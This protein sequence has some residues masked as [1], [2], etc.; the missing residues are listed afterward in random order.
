VKSYK[1]SLK[2]PKY[3]RFNLEPGKRT[4]LHQSH[5]VELG[6][7]YTDYKIQGATVDK[8]IL[9]LQKR[10]CVPHLTIG[11]VHVGL[12]RVKKGDDIRIW[13]MDITP[14]SVQHLTKLRRSI[15][16]KIWKSNYNNGRWDECGL[17]HISE[18]EYRKKIL[19]LNKIDLDTQNVKKLRKLAMHLN[20]Q[21]R[22]IPQTALIDRLKILQSSNKKTQK[23]NKKRVRKSKTQSTDSRKSVNKRIKTTSTKN[24]RK[25]TQ[26]SR[27]K[28]K[29]RT[30]RN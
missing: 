20:I 6:F 18:Q 16:L 2:V 9:M 5:A 27:R 4:L 19:E 25:T 30:K 3:M 23:T 14:E 24:K 13:P 17:R 1:S 7:A 26:K 8:L 22:S 11:S 28:S 21:H 12:T 29:K 10:P 15:G